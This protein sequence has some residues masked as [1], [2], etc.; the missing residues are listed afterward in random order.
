MDEEILIV[1]GISFN[2]IYLKSRYFVEVDDLQKEETDDIK[3]IFKSVKFLLYLLV[4][5]FFFKI[6]NQVEFEELVNE[7]KFL[8]V[9]YVEKK[10]NKIFEYFE[11]NCVKVWKEL[12]DFKV[13][14]KIYYE[15]I[16]KSFVE[17]WNK[18]LCIVLMCKRVLE[19]VDLFLEDYYKF[20][21][22]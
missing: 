10:I 16:Q 6:V 19:V 5:K 4:Y 20:R 8:F 18:G 22:L 17:F 1:F 11:K 12:K 13:Y 7:V 21:L 9:V 14:L 15:L 3:I 2:M